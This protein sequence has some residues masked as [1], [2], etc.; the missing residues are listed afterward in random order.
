MVSGLSNATFVGKDS[1]IVQKLSYTVAHTLVRNLFSVTFVER[2]TLSKDTSKHIIDGNIPVRKFPRAMFV[3]G[4]FQRM[5]VLS[6]IVARKLM[7]I[8]SGV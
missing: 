1:H 2:N 7:D 5:V 8:F 4:D 3:E 6:N